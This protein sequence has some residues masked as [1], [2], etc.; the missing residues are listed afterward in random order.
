MTAVA[1]ESQVIF[2]RGLKVQLSPDAYTPYFCSF[3]T[4]VHWIE[5]P[6]IAENYQPISFFPADLAGSSFAGL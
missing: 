1:I 5:G 3:Y 6:A 2:E 4:L